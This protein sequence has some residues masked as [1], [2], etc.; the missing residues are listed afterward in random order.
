MTKKKLIARGL[1]HW[2]E[3]EID[4]F[5]QGWDPKVDEP[6]IRS[7][8]LSTCLSCNLKCIYCYAGEK[9]RLEDE[10]TCE[11]QKGIII[12]AEEL[13]AEVVLICGDAEPLMDENLVDIVEQA[14]KSDMFP[15]VVTNGVMLGNDKL[16]EKLHGM[17]A[18]ELTQLLYDYG[19]SLVVKMD[20]IKPERYDKIVGVKSTYPKFMNAVYNIGNVGF[21]NIME[22]QNGFLTRLAFSTVTMRI[23]I[24]E[25]E[26]MKNFANSIN[27][28]Y[29]CKLPTLVGNALENI[30]LM[31]PPGSY[32]KIRSEILNKISAKRETLL[33]DGMRCMA[34]HY[35]CVID[36]RGEVRECYTAPC[37]AENRIGNIR[38]YPLVELLKR[39][40]KIF[41]LF[42]NDVCPVK[43]RINEDL[44]KKE[45]KVLYPLKPNTRE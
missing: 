26:E 25:L 6:R 36:N 34:W 33:S 21:T 12:Q 10:L 23:N 8:G 39:R 27:A 35:G 14:Y 24:T 1:D 11:E 42:M 4:K 44:M 2:T 19:A 37:S 18:Y 28:Q 31:F 32:E 20:S 17:S 16:A 7:V 5:W 9:K 30:D 41:N 22:R 40:N 29:I 43:K 13:G 38:E 45:G 3:E 15:V